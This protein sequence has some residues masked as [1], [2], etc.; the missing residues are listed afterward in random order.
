MDQEIEE[1]TMKKVFQNQ[2]LVKNRENFKCCL[3]VPIVEK[4]KSFWFHI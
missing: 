4:V 3:Y 1:E 2:E